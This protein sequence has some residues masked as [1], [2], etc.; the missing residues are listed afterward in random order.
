MA[1]IVVNDN[2]KMFQIQRFLGL[3]ENMDGDTQL[4]LGEASNI[5]NFRVTQQYHLQGRPGT[6]AIKTFEGPVRG[7]WSGYV[8][9]REKMLCAADGAVWDI[10]EE[11]ARRIGDI[12]DDETTFFG[13]NDK[14]YVLNGHEDMF[15][16]GEGY[17][18]VVQGYVPLVATAV[19]PAGGGTTLENINL[20][21]GK[22]RIQFSADGESTEYVLPEKN[23]LAVEK[24][25]T[26]GS[27]TPSYTADLENGTITFASAPLE[28]SANVEI[29]YSVKNVL[30]SQVESMRFCES[31][32]G[33]AETR[34]FLY[35]NGTA[36]TIYC[37]VTTEGI[38]SA[39]Y[40]PDLYEITVGDSNTPITGMVKHYDRLLTFKPDGAFATE[41]SSVT[42]PD[43]TVTAGFYTIPLNREIGN[44]APGQVRL[45]YN[46][47]RTMFH[48][49]LY[50]WKM[51]SSTVRDE[52]NAKLVSDKV[53]QTMKRA[54]AKSCFI[55]DDDGSQENYIFLNDEQGT[56]PCHRYI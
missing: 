56:A 24:V 1:N 11:P 45:V 6:R 52:R 22:R 30:R 10:T 26:Y 48:R 54:D 31:F 53:Q 12:F 19:S 17:V 23:L 43:G 15:W 7:L 51:T 5:E 2:S 9:G 8:A 35:G 3:N 40:F 44:E 46:Y 20:L 38:A 33:A 42:L 41:Y 21:T 50:D 18:D 34:I 28:G 49:N 25:T 47:P 37:G 32:N 55:F 16:D 36:K 4:K 29:L 39:E 13:F 14:V 27:E